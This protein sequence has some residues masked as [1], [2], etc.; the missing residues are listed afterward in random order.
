[1][2]I[3]IVGCLIARR[4]TSNTNLIRILVNADVVE[5]QI[6]RHV[7]ADSVI[8]RGKVI[9]HAQVHDH[10]H[11]LE[12]DHAL[13]DV[14]VGS[15]GAAVE[16]PGFVGADEPGHVT[17]SAGGVFEGVDLVFAAVVPVRV[18]VCEARHCLLVDAAAVGVDLG[19]ARVVDGGKVCNCVSY[20]FERR[21]IEVGNHRSQA[22]TR[23]QTGQSVDSAMQCRC[24]ARRRSEEQCFLR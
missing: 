2:L 20:L 10:G 19:Y 13:A 11:G 22:C 23:Y 1:M 7:L 12:R 21:R 18:E 3:D 4:V 9:R 16:G 17:S 6:R 24:T 15:D 14:A 8:L 5:P